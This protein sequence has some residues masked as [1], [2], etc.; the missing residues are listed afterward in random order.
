M[1]DALAQLFSHVMQPC[2]DLTGNWWASI[3]LFT[4]II[5]VVLMPLALWCQYNSIVMVRIMPALNRVKVQYFGDAE[6]I[7]ERQ[8]R[9]NKEYHYHPM[10]SLVPLAVQVIILFGLVEVIHGVTDHGAPGTEFLGLVPATDGGLA[11]VMPFLAALS[12]VIMGEASNRINPLQKEQTRLEK[13]TTNGISVALSFVLGIYVAAGMAFY[14]ICSNLM[15]ILVQVLCN[16]IVNPKRFVDYEELEASKAELEQLNSLSKKKGPWWRP[17]PLAKREKADYKRFFG[18]VDKH[19][20]FYSERSGYYK[21]FQGAIEWLLAHSNARIHY[22]TNDA[23]DKIFELAK[24]QPRIMPYYVG[25]KRAITLM[26]KM[27]ADVVVLTLD[28]LDNYYIKRSYVRK[29]VKYVHMPHHMTSMFLTAAE[30]CYDH[31]DA[32]LS[33]GPHQVREI[34]RLEQMNG[35]PAKHMVECG[36]DLLDRQIAE[37][38]ARPKPHHDRPVVLI[39]PSWQEDNLLDLCGLETIR[40]LIAGGFHVIV[41]PHPEYLKRYRPRWEALCAAL[42]DQPKELLSLDQDFSSNES[43][44]DADVII[45]DWSSIYLEFSFITLKPSLLINTPMRVANPDWEKL[46]IEPT[47]ISLRREIGRGVEVADLPGIA[48]VA[49]ELVDDATQWAERIREVR[50]RTVFNLGHGGENAGRFLLDTMLAQQA[51]RTGDAV[52]TKDGEDEKGGVGEASKRNAKEATD[53]AH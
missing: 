19:I 21:Y 53:E 22:V 13:N 31:Y 18:T 27:D 8:T 15:S 14:W 3:A 34:R 52:A 37:Y 12:A 49:H 35:L 51:K 45:T 42:A 41:R 28:D 48:D 24:E 30:H 40:P 17:D 29:D 46:G 5:K 10:L 25:E 23:T 26:M 39:A 4:L 33:V 43:I 50:E 44:Y 2:Y 9:L 7:G 32:M 16:V 20:V 47:D 6:T 11:W 36:Y 1:L 38:D